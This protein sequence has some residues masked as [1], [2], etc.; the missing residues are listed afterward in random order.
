[1]PCAAD[2]A[3]PEQVAAPDAGVL[4]LL[5]DRQRRPSTRRRPVG[6]RDDL[7]GGV[8]GGRQLGVGA[9][10]DRWP[11][12]LEQPGKRNPVLVGQFQKRSWGGR[13]GVSGREDRWG[14]SCGRA[15]GHN[16]RRPKGYRALGAASG[17]SRL[18]EFGAGVPGRL[19]WGVR[20]RH[21]CPDD[22]A[23]LLHCT[24]VGEPG[25]DL[26]AGLVVPLGDVQVLLLLAP[27]RRAAHEVGSALQ[28]RPRHAGPRQREVVG[29]EVGAA[30][31]RLLVRRDLEA[32]RP[33]PPARWPGPAR[34]GRGPAPRSR[35]SG[36]RG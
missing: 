24:V 9:V 36:R 3:R 21:R 13:Q 17:L 27:A 29:P 32:P 25:L 35:G 18:P 34:T 30:D 15:A 31:Q 4:L 26:V 7:R 2:G 12:V 8:P 22:D 5:D 28:A 14:G 19:A 16:C 6:G 11:G 33:R 1:M 10:P 20:Q 23:K